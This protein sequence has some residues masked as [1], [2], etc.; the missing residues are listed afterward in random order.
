MRVNRY[1]ELE[2]IPGL[3]ATTLDGVNK[4]WIMMVVP[5]LAQ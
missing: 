2:L 1:V 5:G 3:D 4:P